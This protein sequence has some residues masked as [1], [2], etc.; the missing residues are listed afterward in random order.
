MNEPTDGYW[1]NVWLKKP[2]V[3]CYW[4]GRATVDWMF[5]TCYSGEAPWNDSH[6]HHARFDKLLKEARAELDEKRR[7][8]MYFECQKLVNEEG[9]VIVY[10]FK[11]N[12]E[13]VSDKIK[14][15][16]VAGNWEADGCK[17]SERWWFKA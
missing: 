2:F 4:N 1:S 10:L 17:A 5:S 9:G 15:G 11:D 16:N 7:A 6:F 13:A 8:E 14:F 12:V 3:S